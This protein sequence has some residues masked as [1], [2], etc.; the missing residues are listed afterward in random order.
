MPYCKKCDPPRRFNTLSAL[1][2]HQWADHKNMIK[3]LP[4]VEE[5]VPDLPTV[6]VEDAPK[7]KAPPKAPPSKAK[8]TVNASIV[9]RLQMA[10]TD[11]EREQALV[12]HRFQLKIAAIT[13]PASASAE[14][15]R[16]MTPEGKARVAEAQRKRWAK[17]QEAATQAAGA[18]TA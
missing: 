8:V 6:T 14:V 7:R 15:K 2:K 4:A 5:V 1:R 10:I 3:K 11:Y 18:P 9:E 13:N 16:G 17:K 12:E